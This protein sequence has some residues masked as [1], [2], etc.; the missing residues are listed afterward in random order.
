MCYEKKTNGGAVGGVGER[1]RCP[2]LVVREDTCGDEI[3]I[4][5]FDSITTGVSILASTMQGEENTA[6]KAEELGI[7]FDVEYSNCEQIN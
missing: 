1:I 6:A 2:A 3:K 4:A 5:S 7:I